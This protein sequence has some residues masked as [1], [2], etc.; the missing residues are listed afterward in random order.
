MR[1]LTNKTTSSSTFYPSTIVFFFSEQPDFLFCSCFGSDHKKYTGCVKIFDTSENMLPDF[2][3]YDYGAGFD[4]L[5]FGDRY[6]HKN[7]YYPNQEIQNRQ[8]V[9]KDM[10]QR[11]FCNFI[12]SNDKNGEGAE[13]R[14]LFCQK[15]MHY[16]HVDCPGQ[17][18]NN[19][20]ATDLEP[21]NGK[22]EKSKIDFLKKYKFTIAFE[23]SS[24]DGYTTEKLYHPFM[25]GS[26]PIYWGNPKVTCDFNPKAF[27]NCHDYNNDWDAVIQKVIELDNDPDAYLKMLAEPPFRP[28]FERKEQFEKWLIHIIEKGNH[29]YT[30]DPLWFSNK[31]HKVYF[32]FKLKPFGLNL[33]SIKERPSTIV[34]RFLLSFRII[35]RKNICP[36][37]WTA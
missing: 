31:I 21:R 37:V 19:M 3:L 16:K 28:N 7:Y 12:Y 24:S 23:N 36:D 15:L 26:I 6:F 29:P 32:S 1:A 34:W 35:I 17:V 22:W 30:K 18:L 4:Y 14:K 5:E 20:T 13:L 2:N 9:S 27:I 10:S 8:F 11:R 33:L 25:A